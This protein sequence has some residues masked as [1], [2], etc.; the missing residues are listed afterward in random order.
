LACPQHG[1]ALFGKIKRQSVRD[2]TSAAARPLLLSLQL[3]A[4]AGKKGGD[5][6]GQLFKS[7]YARKKNKF[8]QGGS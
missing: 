4:E 8:F 3:Q 2:A 1:T 5:M 7:T 6:E